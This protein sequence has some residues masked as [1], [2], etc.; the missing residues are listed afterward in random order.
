M[1][2][3][4]GEARHYACADGRVSVSS[5]SPRRVWGFRRCLWR[6]QLAAP[7]ALLPLDH[8]GR[9][10]RKHVRTGDVGGKGIGYPIGAGRAWIPGQRELPIPLQGDPHEAQAT[11]RSVDHCRNPGRCLPR[12]QQHQAVRA[13]GEAGR[14][15]RRRLEM[16]GRLQPRCPQ[17]HRSPR[18]PGCGRPDHARPR[19]ASRR[20]WCRWLLPVRCC[21]LLARRSCA[22]AV[23]RGQ[24]SSATWSI[25]PWPPSWRGVA[26]AQGPS[27]GRPSGTSL[28]GLAHAGSHQEASRTA[29]DSFPDQAPKR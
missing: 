10:G 1:A 17:G 25:S 21:C 3:S 24:R 12:R 8:A 13:Q 27:P 5:G 20:Y 4:S 16:G 19:S 28:A 11:P 26:S 29:D 22:C 6:S 14:Y 15:G 2:L 7:L 18:V 9:R 23:A